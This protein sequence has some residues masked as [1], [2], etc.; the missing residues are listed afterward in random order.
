MSWE[1]HAHDYF[2]VILFSIIAKIYNILRYVIPQHMCNLHIKETEISQKRSKGI[3]NW[4]ITYSVI[5]SV[6]SNK[7]NLILGFSS[8]LNNEPEAFNFRLI[9]TLP[10]LNLDNLWLLSVDSTAIILPVVWIH[11][12]VWRVFVLCLSGSVLERDSRLTLGWQN[13]T[14]DVLAKDGEKKD[15][16]C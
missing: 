4:K 15:I 5:V 11:L 2:E 16:I 6:L 9:Y 3:K 8:P 12:V 1:K 13:C 10:F 14:L 7:T